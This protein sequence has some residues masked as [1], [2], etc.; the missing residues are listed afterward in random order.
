MGAKFCMKYIIADPD[1]QHGIELK[2]I[3]DSYEMLEYQGSY[4]TF[5]AEENDCLEH[6]PDIAFI[7]MGK[8]EL[9]AFRLASEIKVLNP[10][11]KVIF[12]STNKENA[13]EAFEYGADGFLLMPFNK[14]Q[15]RQILL[16]NLIDIDNK[17]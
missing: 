8:V 2:K 3:L 13:L 10:F 14:K 7:S 1:V 16:N 17:K 15:I 4:K 6:L 5:Q 12:I 9:N 11:L